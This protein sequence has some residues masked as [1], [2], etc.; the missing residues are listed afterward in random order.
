MQ[1]GHVSRCNASSAARWAGC[2]QG[3]FF[4]PFY[5]AVHQTLAPTL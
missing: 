4:L 2:V 1:N 5:W 3:L